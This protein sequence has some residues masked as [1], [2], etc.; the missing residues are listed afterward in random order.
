MCIHVNTHVLPVVISFER[1]WHESYW[2][3]T[4]NWYGFTSTCHHVKK[5][6]FHGKHVSTLTH[7]ICSQNPLNSHELSQLNSWIHLQNMWN[8]RSL[9]AGRTYKYTN[10]LLPAVCVCVLPVCV[11]P[12]CVAGRQR[13]TQP[14]HIDLCCVVVTSAYFVCSCERAR[15]G[16]EVQRAHQVT[17]L[18]TQA[19][20]GRLLTAMSSLIH[21]RW[22]WT[23]V[24]VWAVL[25][26]WMYRCRQFAFNVRII[27]LCLKSTYILA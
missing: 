20:A 12:V 26:L 18:V 4:V 25:W 5:L 23:V 9:F 1:V 8:H 17:T 22:V 21:Y 11:L 13:Q 24:S 27:K 2:V 6:W 15:T 3:R 14:R 16:G 10:R 19:A 7:Q